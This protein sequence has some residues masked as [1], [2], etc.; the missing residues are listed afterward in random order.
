MPE[1]TQGTSLALLRTAER[2]RDQARHPAARV[3][4]ALSRPP[5]AVAAVLP[6][7]P[8]RRRRRRMAAIG[9]PLPPARPPVP[10]VAPTAGAGRKPARAQGHRPPIGGLG[11]DQLRQRLR[12]DGLELAPVYVEVGARGR[13]AVV[14]AIGDGGHPEGLPGRRGGGEHVPRGDER[15][16]EAVVGEA[17]AEL[18]Q[19]VC[20]ALRARV[21]QE[22]YVCGTAP[23][24]SR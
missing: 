20:M 13:P 10:P 23:V 6:T 19:R 17:A 11:A 1:G 18:E 2:R 16:A 15:G 8:R 12:A 24:G 3:Q 7:P 4:T 21:R 22:Q 5:P 14:E 9:T